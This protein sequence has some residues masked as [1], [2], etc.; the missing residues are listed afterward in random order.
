MLS[1]KLFPLRHVA[2]AVCVAGICAAVP[3]SGAD[4]L[5]AVLDRMDQA[6]ARFKGLSAEVTK[7]SHNALLNEDDT[8]TGTMAVKNGPKAHDLRAVV[9]ILHP[10]PKKVLLTSHKVE[11]YYPK[12]NTVQTVDLDRKGRALVDQFLLLGFGST[13]AEIR[14]AYDVKLSGTETVAGQKTARLLLTPKSHDVLAKLTKVDLW[15]SDTL[16]IAVQQKFWE[17][18]GDYNLLTYTNVRLHTATQELKWDVPKNAKQEK[19]N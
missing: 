13:S 1:R 19:L 7:V 10:D 18:G 4:E 5:Q 9:D 3:A 2:L 14:K 15:I 16:G 6:A 8:F 11:M 12:I 17:P